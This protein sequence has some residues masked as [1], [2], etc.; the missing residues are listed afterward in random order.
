MVACHISLFLM[1]TC[2]TIP[3]V[4]VGEQRLIF[5]GRQLG[6]E[7]TLSQCSVER[8]KHAQELHALSPVP[9]CSCCICNST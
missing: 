2:T 6:D 1:S 4:P 3:G 5:A 9:S 7:L 8:G